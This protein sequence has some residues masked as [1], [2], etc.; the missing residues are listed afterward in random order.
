LPAVSFL[1]A[2]AYQDGH[3]GYSNPLDEQTFLV[4]TINFLQSLPQWGQMLVVVTW[5]DSGGWYDHQKSPI[6]KQ[7]ALPLT[8]IEPSTIA[9]DTLVAPGVCNNYGSAAA[10]TGSGR[11]GYGPRVP[12]L[13]ISP[14]AKIN[15]VDHTLI[16]QTS[17][18]RFIEDNWS[19]TRVGG[20]SFDQ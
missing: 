7:S 8:T 2:P 20:G 4:N 15:F 16:D 5:N 10:T 13:V 1:K 12:F 9:G 11:C 17:I 18:L 19:L 3:Q 6:V 14:F